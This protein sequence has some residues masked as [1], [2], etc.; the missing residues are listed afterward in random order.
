LAQGPTCR[1]FFSR[2]QPEYGPFSAFMHAPPRINSGPACYVG[3]RNASRWL[4]EKAPM[5]S[6]NHKKDPQGRFGSFAGVFTP[7][8]L[9]IMRLKN[10]PQSH[11]GLP[12]R[13]R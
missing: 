7:N 9:T 5:S 2:W 12:Q 13:T 11:S 10:I 1:T 4:T 3:D 6:H 8:V